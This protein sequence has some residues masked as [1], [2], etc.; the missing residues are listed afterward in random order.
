MGYASLTLGINDRN[1]VVLPAGTAANVTLVLGFVCFRGLR[2]RL[3]YLNP[4]RAVFL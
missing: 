4:H 3:R 2:R 1:Y